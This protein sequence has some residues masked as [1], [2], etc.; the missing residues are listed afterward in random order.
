MSANPTYARIAFAASPNPEAEE[1]RQRL[2]K[3]YGDAP[4]DTADVIVALGGDGLMLQSLHD[5][6]GSSRPIYGMH[7]GTVG[8]MMNEFREDRLAQR[9]PPPA[10]PV[11]HPPVVAGR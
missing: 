6:M 11:T 5:Q 10:T 1:A 9:L 8:F 2:A 4:I 3:R 7:R